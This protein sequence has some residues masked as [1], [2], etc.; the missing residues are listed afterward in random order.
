LKLIVNNGLYQTV[1][2]HEF[3][4]FK[5]ELIP[6]FENGRILKTHALFK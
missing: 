4:D 2:E 3:P 1:K 5:D 6:I